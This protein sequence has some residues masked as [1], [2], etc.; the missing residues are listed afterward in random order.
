MIARLGKQKL[1]KPE[2]ATLFHVEQFE[3]TLLVS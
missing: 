2:S 3:T 1:E